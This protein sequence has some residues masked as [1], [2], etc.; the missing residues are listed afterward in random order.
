MWS[1]GMVTYTQFMN[2]GTETC[3]VPGAPIPTSS[4]TNATVPLRGSVLNRGRSMDAAFC[5][6]VTAGEGS[7]A[8]Y[9]SEKAPNEA[10]RPTLELMILREPRVI[11]GTLPPLEDKETEKDVKAVEKVRRKKQKNIFRGTTQ[12]MLERKR[13]QI[14][15]ARTLSKAEKNKRDDTAKRRHHL[16]M[17]IFMYER[18]VKRNK[19]IMAKKASIIVQNKTETDQ[20]AVAAKVMATAGGGAAAVAKKWGNFSANTGLMRARELEKAARKVYTHGHYMPLRAALKTMPHLAKVAPKVGAVVNVP[21]RELGE[22]HGH[23]VEA[24]AVDEAVREATG[25]AVPEGQRVAMEKPS[26]N[27]V[28]LLSAGAADTALETT[29]ATAMSE[30]LKMELVQLEENPPY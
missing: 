8:E 16:E 18:A 7:Y 6:K 27:D 30:D 24:E 13:E 22:Q 2:K 20:A 21:A 26:E 11:N 10:D 29:D 19:L 15:G 1:R 28:A 17:A 14:P 25:L 5:F 3:S 4:A 12:H 9:S 23:S